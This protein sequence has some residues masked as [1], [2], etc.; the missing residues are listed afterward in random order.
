V[1]IA[2]LLISLD[3]RGKKICDLLRSEVETWFAA[4]GSVAAFVHQPSDDEISSAL[5]TRLSGRPSPVRG[6]EVRLVGELLADGT[7]AR[8][9]A[10]TES[11]PRLV[12]GLLPGLPADTEILMLVRHE[13]ATWTEEARAFLAGHQAP[14]LWLVSPFNGR[15]FRED[16]LDALCARFLALDIAVDLPTHL[17]DSERPRAGIAS[18][19]LAGLVIPAEAIV[20]RAAHRLAAEVLTLLASSDGAGAGR[21]AGEQWLSTRRLRFGDLIA[22][23]RQGTDIPLGE[24]DR[25]VALRAGEERTWPDR[26]WS[27]F[28]FFGFEGLARQEHRIADNR[29][30]ALTTALEALEETVDGLVTRSR[31]PVPALRFLEE[32]AQ[33]AAAERGQRMEVAG[34]RSHLHAA[35]EKLKEAYMRLPSSLLGLALRVWAG[36]FAAA[37]PL[38]LLMPAFW[39]AVRGH[40]LVSFWGLWLLLGLAGSAVAALFY[41]D[42]HS[43]FVKA[44]LNAEGAL[45]KALEFVVTA[46]VHNSALDVLNTILCAA[47]SPAQREE[48]RLACDGVRSLHDAVGAYIV[49]LREASEAARRQGERP[50]ITAPFLSLPIRLPAGVTGVDPEHVADRLVADGFHRGWRDADTERLTEKAA[51]LIA[52]MVRTSEIPTVAEAFSAG[53]E[54]SALV[55]NLVESAR[56][57]LALG[58]GGPPPRRLVFAHGGAGSAVAERWRAVDPYSTWRSLEDPHQLVVLSVVHGLAAG[59]LLGETTVLR[60][61]HE[62]GPPG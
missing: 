17:W 24:R 8:L 21:P 60:A 13:K 15:L 43:D 46:R 6:L 5:R 48:L 4:D 36:A 52:Q 11:V 33:A 32:L 42:R 40:L 61:G 12:S 51:D 20:A 38:H 3:D 30:R 14:L 55:R 56:P 29:G 57:L 47:A 44:K 35:I 58:A 23:I 26:L 27:V 18:F 31:T 10:L 49:R 28:Y 25:K 34:A 22:A 1:A 7:L 19:G 2:Y 41:L 37:Y 53:P 39:P 50:V 59:D 62:Q 45:W 9:S 54:A 16:E